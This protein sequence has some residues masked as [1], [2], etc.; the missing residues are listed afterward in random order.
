VRGL[1]WVV[2]AT[3]K[4]VKALRQWARMRTGQVTMN[5]R[6]CPC[7][8]HAYGLRGSQSR[9]QNTGAISTC[10]PSGRSA[11]GKGEGAG[12]FARQLSSDPCHLRRRAR[13]ILH[14]PAPAPR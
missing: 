7:A 8:D 13:R 1:R 5:E 9:L 12:S 4:T 14:P 11:L 6:E 2:P 3:L 10:F